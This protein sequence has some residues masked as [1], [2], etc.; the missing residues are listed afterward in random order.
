MWPSVHAKWSGVDD[1]YNLLTDVIPRTLAASE[2]RGF[3][4]R[5]LISAPASTSAVIELQMPFLAARCNGVAPFCH[6]ESKS[7]ST[8]TNLIELVDSLGR[9]VPDVLQH[10]DIFFQHQFPQ[11][12]FHGDLKTSLKHGHAHSNR[13]FNLLHIIYSDVWSL[14]QPHTPTPLLHTSSS[15]A[16]YNVSSGFKRLLLKHKWSCEGQSSP[17]SIA[18]ATNSCSLLTVSSTRI[19]IMGCLRWST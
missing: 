18:S 14:R 2:V 15:P 7:M 6:C 19:C 17:S 11:L 16:S 5:A 9:E 8:L 13:S 12:Q 3:P 1:P 10:G 4:V